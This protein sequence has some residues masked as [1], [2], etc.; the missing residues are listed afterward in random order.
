IDK[1]S[2]ELRSL[3]H[4]MS[5]QKL[6]DRL[7]LVS[8]AHVDQ[9]GFIARL[10]TRSRINHTARYSYLHTSVFRTPRPTT[11]VTPAGQH[12]VDIGQQPKRKK[13]CHW[14]DSPSR[15]TL[16]VLPLAH[17]RREN[18]Q[19]LFNSVGATGVPR[20]TLLFSRG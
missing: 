2:K 19:H 10:S 14:R 9:R 13:S 16:L 15:R 6:G 5:A 17:F 18:Q 3:K 7:V 12:A 8:D 1:K 4:W 11:S 20:I